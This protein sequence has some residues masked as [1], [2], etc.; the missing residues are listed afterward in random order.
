MRIHILILGFKGL[1]LILISQ[2]CHNMR[3][4]TL[5][6]LSFFFLYTFQA[7]AAGPE[8]RLS[9]EARP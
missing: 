9:L 7:E 3:G 8:M 1:K 5:F 6:F 4:E 2:A